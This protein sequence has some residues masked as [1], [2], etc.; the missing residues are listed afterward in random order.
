MSDGRC[1]EQWEHEGSDGSQRR[2]RRRTDV[3]LRGTLAQTAQME[4][5]TNRKLPRSQPRVFAKSGPPV[6][7]WSQWPMH[8]KWRDFQRECGGEQSFSS[9]LSHERRQANT[10]PHRC[11]RSFS[12]PVSAGSRQLRLIRKQSD[13]LTDSGNSS[14]NGSLIFFLHFLKRN[15][16]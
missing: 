5:Q 10:H 11:K 6:V 14:S 8:H 1:P 9:R 7:K 3:G 13:C 4:M 16:A 12:R 15:P 2:S